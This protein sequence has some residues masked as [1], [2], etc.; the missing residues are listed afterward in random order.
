M[1]LPNEPRLPFFLQ[2]LYT[3]LNPTK[4]LESC[5]QLYGETFS[6]RLLGQNSP[7][8]VF[9]SNP[10][11][12]GTIFVTEAAKFELGKIT[13]VFQ[14]L[15]G[16]ESLIMQDGK[17]HQRTRQLLMPAT[18]GEQLNNYSQLIVELVLQAMENWHSG[19]C[20]SIRDW[21]SEISLEIILR[22]VFGLNNGSRYEELKQLIKPFLEY[23]NSPLNSIQFFW[24]PLQQD[25]GKWS[26]WGKFLRQ[27]QQIDALIYAEIES[28]R[29]QF[30]KNVA[31]GKSTGQD[32]LSLLISAYDDDGQS[33]SD[34]ELRDQL[35]TLLFLGHD[36]TASALAWAFYW[37]YS[38][39]SVLQKLHHE[40]D[41]LHPSNALEI[42][43]L[44]YLTAVCK[45]SLR[46]Y[47][48][49]LISQPRVVTQ[50]V[51]IEDYEFEPGAIL[52]PCIYLAHRR[53]EVYPQPQLFKPERFLSRKFSPHE[54]L[55]F[56]GGSR[57]CIGMGLS[58]LEM[59]LI[60]ATVLSHYELTLLDK[61]PAK[62]VRRGITIVP[63]GECQMVVKAQRR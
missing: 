38:E 14:P 41:T 5:A 39:P 58:M 11:T 9:F 17:R 43:Q 63:S 46:I 20:L 23:V 6:L 4:F 37:I 60:I 49:A 8:I 55:P 28:R 32:I 30:D 33:M 40:L 53:P 21:M 22:V 62:P 2:T 3:I 10:Q 16:P 1:K 42:T 34:S 25:L 19:L 31:H 24:T 13:H 57:S 44:P 29:Q 59:K 26:P 51:Q 27:Q 18:H 7:P 56:G 52:I 50:T 61:R 36:T 12:I 15:T 35:L 47:P 54:Y 48:I 45:E